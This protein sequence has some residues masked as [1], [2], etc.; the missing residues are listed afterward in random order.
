M[1]TS[2]TLKAEKRA[3]TGSGK[4]NQMRAE[5]SVPA[6]MYGAGFENVNLKLNAREFASVLASSI[7]EHILVTL[8]IPEIGNKMALVKD[9]QRNA[10]TGQ[11]IHVDFLQVDE[12]TEIHATVPV[13]LHGE[14]AGI[15]VGGILEQ[16]IHDID[17]KCL[18]KDL[19]ESIVVDITD[20][21]L[22]QTLTIGAL[23][24]PK[25]VK[26]VLPDDVIVALISASSAALSDGMAAAEEQKEA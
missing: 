16:N 9:V 24:L 6:I 15:K 7:S 19:P 5:G 3:R 1:A 8:E 20:L 11:F 12:N 22:N 13:V 21:G 14:P 26:A 23:S 10:I 4:L 18:S 17:V 25:G 2:H